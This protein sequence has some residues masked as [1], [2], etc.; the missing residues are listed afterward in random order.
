[1]MTTKMMMMQPADLRGM[2]IALATPFTEDF[3]VDYSSLGEMIDYQIASG[4]DYIVALATTSEAVT[5]TLPERHEVARFVR[6]RVAGRVPLV[7]GMSG[8]CTA[9]VVAHIQGADLNDYCAILSVVPYYNKPSQEGI[10]RHFKAI[11]EASPLPVILYNVPSRTGVNMTADTTLRLAAEFPGK[12]VA[13][14]E[15]SGNVAQISDIIARKP[16]GFKVL[17]G[18]DGLT[19]S[20]IALGAEGVIS[21]VGNAL[22]RIFTTMVHEALA[23]P[24]SP[25]AV[26][27]DQAMQPLCRALFADGNPSGLKSLLHTLG[28]GADVLRLPLVPVSAPT[29]TELATQTR[30]LRSL[31]PDLMPA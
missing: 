1:M 11:A 30:V 19:R 20:L 15:A 13:I 28:M 23:D 22:P 4:A 27:I 25:R 7:I 14:K 5:L 16:Q 2:G 10:Y 8:N 24:Q 6:N 3:S 9:E 31:F 21:V 12:I 17:S 29:A 26:A 18:D